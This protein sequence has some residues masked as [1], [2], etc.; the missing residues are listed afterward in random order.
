MTNVCLQSP[1]I[2]IH[3]ENNLR[4]QMET[5]TQLLTNV[6]MKEIDYPS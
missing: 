4:L 1:L 6:E 5:K 2:R 3:R